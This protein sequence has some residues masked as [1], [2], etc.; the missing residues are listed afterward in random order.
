MHD[1]GGFLILASLLG[2]IAAVVGLIR[3][4]T[5]RLP[6]RAWSLGIWLIS[7]ALFAGGG[8]LLDPPSDSSAKQDAPS[9]TEEPDAP[10]TPNNPPLGDVDCDWPSL[11]FAEDATA[12][13]V[14]HCLAAGSDPNATD[15]DG[16]TQLHYAARY[17][18]A[19]VI[20]ALT[21]GGADP[22]AGGLWTWPVL[23]EAAHL[24]ENAEVINALVAAGADPN[25]K[26]TRNDSGWGV[27]R[28][29]HVAAFHSYKPEIVEALLMNGAD[30][31]IPGHFG[32]LVFE[33]ASNNPR[34]RDSN[35][36][37]LLREAVPKG[38]ALELCW[39]EVAMTL[40]RS[41]SIVPVLHE[42]Q[43]IVGGGNR[44]EL[45]SSAEIT[46]ED[47][48]EHVPYTCVVQDG[49]IVDFRIHE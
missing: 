47:D 6:T 3:P 20:E 23:H 19:A 37:P 13:K 46:L 28:P 40:F 16:R 24:T 35:I 18:D 4:R 5:L 34:M 9:R 32:E 43:S 10:P 41:T 2:F 26:D 27:N 45:I 30:P 39:N 48:T 21:A 17:D 44:F 7:V 22:N 14:R 12:A 38:E 33:A 42:F 1:L 31:S 29:L 15:D 11:S 36:M 25:I 49:V 8:S